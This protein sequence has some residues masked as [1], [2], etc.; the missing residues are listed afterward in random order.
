L[1]LRTGEE[2]AESDGDDTET[3]KPLRTQGSEDGREPSR[4]V[5]AERAGFEPADRFDPIAALAKQFETAENPV[6]SGIPAAAA[7][8]G[9]A[10]GAAAHP[11]LGRIVASWASLP[12]PI[13]AAM[14]ALVSSV[15]TPTGSGESG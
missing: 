2:T 11:D 15:A 10:P 8:S 4:T 14:L 7:M 3:Q 9:A 1:R 12:V 13:R 6:I 5:G